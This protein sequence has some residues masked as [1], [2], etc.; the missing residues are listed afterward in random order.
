MGKETERVARFVEK[1]AGRI[2]FRAR[3]NE[4]ASE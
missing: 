2:I 3:G 1:G 4:L